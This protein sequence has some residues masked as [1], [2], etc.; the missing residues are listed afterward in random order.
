MKKLAFG[1]LLVGL[2][3][4]CGGD[5]GKNKVVN[6]GIVSGAHGSHTAGI[7][8]GNQLFGGAMGGAAPGASQHCRG[9][10]CRASK[11]YHGI[12]Q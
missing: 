4:A 12:P 11:T 9:S 10:D 6:I 1:A 8:A 7:A 5:D 2:L 3:V